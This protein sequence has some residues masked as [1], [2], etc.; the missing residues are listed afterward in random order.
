MKSVISAI[1]IAA[2]L[3]SSQA[4]LAAPPTQS[5]PE[6]R[7]HLQQN[8]FTIAKGKKLPSNVKRSVVH[9]RDFKRLG[10]KKPARGY[11]WVKIGTSYV[12]I[13]VGTGMIMSILGAATR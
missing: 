3:G 8:S 11:Q 12:M 5:G 10:L 6:Q 1:A 2:L 13:A 7:Q 4:A 9:E